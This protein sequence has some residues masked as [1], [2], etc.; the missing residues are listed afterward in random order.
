MTSGATM[1]VSSMAAERVITR[2]VGYPAAKAAVE[3]LTRWLAVELAPAVRVNAVAR[4]FFVG[5][6][7]CRL[8]FDSAASSSPDG[9]RSSTARPP[10]VR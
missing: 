8:L 2:V 3:N 1:N 5:E 9:A 4:D 7:N 10:G 6:Q